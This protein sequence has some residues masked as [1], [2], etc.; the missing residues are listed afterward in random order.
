MLTKL[1]AGLLAAVAVTGAG[2]YF[3]TTNAA[4]SKGGSCCPVSACCVPGADCCDETPKA[5]DCCDSLK[6]C[7]E[8]DEAP[9]AKAPATKSC[10]EAGAACCPAAK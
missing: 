3:A 7:C 4:D 9:A 1:I 6:T 8:A 5:S 10:C 2:V